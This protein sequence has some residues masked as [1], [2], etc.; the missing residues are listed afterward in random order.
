MR[1]IVGHQG[2]DA[3]ESPELP[4][5]FVDLAWRLRVG[6]FRG[7][8][9]D[10]LFRSLGVEY[11]AALN[12]LPN[13]PNNE[14]YQDDTDWGFNFAL[15]VASQLV[16]YLGERPGRHLLF[17]FGRRTQEPLLRVLQRRGT[18]PMICAGDIALISLPHPSG[19]NRDWNHARTVGRCI[20]LV[21]D[22]EF[23]VGQT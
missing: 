11:D 16:G 9:C 1:V 7:E 22:A 13:Y 4:L 17:A 10:K 20:G 5:S 19:K 15:R 23:W 14:L 12:L 18:D 2:N 8:R 21:T 6:A 3:P